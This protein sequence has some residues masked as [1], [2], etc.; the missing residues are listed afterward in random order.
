MVGIAASPVLTVA[1][2]GLVYLAVQQVLRQSANDP[3]IQLAEDAANALAQNE[4]TTNILSG[5]H[6]V[7]VGQSLAPFFLIYDDTGK[8]IASSG[9]LHGEIPSPPLGVFDYTR[10]HGQN[11]ITWQPEPTVR[12]ASVIQHEPVEMPDAA[13]VPIVIMTHVAAAGRLRAAM[14]GISRLSAVA[15][16]GVYYRVADAFPKRR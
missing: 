8:P 2:C 9:L 14:E 12:I 4:T 6:T 7:D 5:A 15:E 16:P 1:L 3:Q 10:T 13:V 11:R